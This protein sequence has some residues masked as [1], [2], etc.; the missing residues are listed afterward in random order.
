[1]PKA[2]RGLSGEGEEACPLGM[3]NPRQV[4]DHKRCV[5]QAVDKLKE[6]ANDEEIS[7]IME[8]FIDEVKSICKDVHTPMTGTDPMK[9]LRAMGDPY[10]LALRPQTEEIENRLDLAMP[11]EEVT[12]SQD[13]LQMIGNIE[14]ISDK[15]KDILITM[16]DHMAESYYHAAQAAEQF[17]Q[18]AHESST[19]QLMLVMKYAV[20]LMVQIEGTIGSGQK[21][22]E[23]KIDL[24]EDITRRVNLTLLLNLMADSLKWE[25]KS[26]PTRLL[27]GIVYYQIYKYFRG[28]CTQTLVVNTFDLKLKNVALCLTGHK[29]HSAKDKQA[30][31]KHKAAKEQKG[32]AKKKTTVMKIKTHQHHLAD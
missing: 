31:T 27:A 10:G 4:E 6:R 18:I 14:P 1:M 15:A 3:I 7:E 17:T 28:S 2:A 32:C 29:Y 11:E 12:E 13:L 20:R 26:S 5:E 22:T 24:P 30:S 8:Q 21:V 16:M 23:K 25:L 19:Q 9:V